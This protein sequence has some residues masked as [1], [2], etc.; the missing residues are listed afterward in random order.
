MPI[1]KTRLSRKSKRFMKKMLS[2]KKTKK[3]KS[4][5]SKS[6]SSYKKSNSLKMR[7][8]RN[9]RNIK[10]HNGGF[11]SAS[12][13]NMVTVK[14][15]GFSVDALGAIAGINIPGSKASIYRPN[16]SAGSPQAMAP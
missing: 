14:E 1:K 6:R 7:K 10:L 12:G 16:C 15:P 5:K 4:M 13:C 8:M 2:H 11:A 3:N 9:I